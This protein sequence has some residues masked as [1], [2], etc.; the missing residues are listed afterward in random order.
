MNWDDLR[1]FLALARTGTLAAAAR[2]SRQ[3]AT[4][5][6]RRLQRLE[7]ALGTALFEH[8]Q[9]GQVLTEAG[10]HLLAH[11]EMM[12]T[13][14]LAIRDE[15][16]GPSLTGSIR[17]SAS[18][19]FGTWFLGHRLGGFARANPRL[20]VDL[21]ATTGFLSPS[22]READVAIMLA[23]PSGG[24]LVASKLTDYRLGIYAAD[25]FLAE[26]GAIRSIADFRRGPIVGYVPDLIYAPE[27]R[28]LSEVDATLEADLRS[29]SINAQARLIA[30]GAG[31]GILP[32]F[33]G[34]VLPGLTRVLRD[35]LSITRQLWL[36]VHR[37]MWRVA[38]I[39]KFVEWLRDEIA[40]AGALIAGDRPDP[41][42]APF[43]GGVPGG[44]MPAPPR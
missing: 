20:C 25:A 36:V 7:K 18:E 21:V 2:V 40:H 24:P 5:I 23:R 8:R 42:G 38:R 3:D 6:S 1:I 19:G 29:S 30:S 35:E 16:A 4:T 27:L 28:Y 10:Q 26:T 14:A 44:A 12:E 22:R 37:D 34:D 9:S 43:A 15:A 13:G 17:V 39:A 32:C 33:I 11:A 31:A 41:D